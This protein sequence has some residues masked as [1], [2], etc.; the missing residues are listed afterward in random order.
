MIAGL[1]LALLVGYRVCVTGPAFEERRRA[2]P[3]RAVV[4]YL[5]SASCRLQEPGQ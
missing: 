5:P 3:P 4:A 1:L 2:A